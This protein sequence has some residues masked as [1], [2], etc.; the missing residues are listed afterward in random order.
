MK[1][2]N[3]VDNIKQAITDHLIIQDTGYGDISDIKVKPEGGVTTSADY[4]Y[5]FINPTLHGRTVNT[6]IYRFN[7]IAMDLVKDDEYLKIQSEC[8][9]YI[10]D[11]IGR[12]KYHYNMEINLD[13]VEYTPFKE[14]FQDQVAGMTAQIQ[15][16][17]IDRLDDCIAPY[18]N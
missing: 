16:T 11:I 2:K 4:P 10:N 13:L 12:L 18:N 14:R 7:L 17:I 15:L 6:M 5:V 1:Y 3:V 8:Q 9:Q